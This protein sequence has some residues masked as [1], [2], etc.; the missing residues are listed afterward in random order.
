M[1]TNIG[2]SFCFFTRSAFSAVMKP[3]DACSASASSNVSTKQI[4]ANASVLARS[5]EVGVLDV[6][7]GDVVGQQHDLVA[8]QFV[9]ILVLQIGGL[10]LLHDADDEVAGAD[11]GIEDVDAFVAER[12]SEFFLQNLFDAAHHE[13]DDGLRRVDDAVGVGL[14]R[15][16]ALE[17]TLINFVEECLLFGEAGGVF[18]A[19][20]YGLVEAVE[21]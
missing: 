11:E 20:L 18:R 6:H 19:L 2:V 8:V 17:E 12:A 9:L 10:D 21:A 13:V 14:F 15:R 5:L 7:A 4:P 3:S 1:T 16:I